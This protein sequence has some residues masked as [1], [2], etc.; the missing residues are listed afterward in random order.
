MIVL[1]DDDDLLVVLVFQDL[2]DPLGDILGLGLVAVTSCETG[3]GQRRVVHCL[4][5]G[6]RLR[7]LS[8]R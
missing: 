6:A 4:E 5:L 3:V 1:G 8:L 2:D 7:D